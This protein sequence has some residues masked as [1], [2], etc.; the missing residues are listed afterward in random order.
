MQLAKLQ[1]LAKKKEF[2][3]LKFFYF[4]RLKISPF[5]QIPSK[6]KVGYKIATG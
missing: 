5:D 4:A 6:K 3:R 1:D 2:I